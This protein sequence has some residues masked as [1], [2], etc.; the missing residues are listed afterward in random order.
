[1]DSKNLNY[2]TLIIIL[3]HFMR[4]YR[5]YIDLSLRDL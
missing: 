2:E 5:Y 1:M 4:N 3:M